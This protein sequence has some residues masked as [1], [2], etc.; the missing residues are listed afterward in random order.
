MIFHFFDLLSLCSKRN[1]KPIKH[2]QKDIIYIIYYFLII[3]K[4]L[5]N[6]IFFDFKIK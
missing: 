5:Y 6:I 1:N 2:F 3:I 4:K